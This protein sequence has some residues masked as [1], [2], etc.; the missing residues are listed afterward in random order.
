[1]SQAGDS[2]ES[3]DA[4]VAALC[5]LAGLAMYVG[6]P[7]GNI[8]GPLLV[9]LLGR[10]RNAFVDDQ[11]KEALNFQISFTIYAVVL[12]ILGVIAFVGFFRTDVVPIAVSGFALLIII[13]V[14]LAVLQFVL[15]IVAAV[16]AG[17]GTRY[18][19]PLTMRLIR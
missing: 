11:G 8:L 6:V 10:S 19:Y 14:I 5:H 18:R 12:F 13:G 2:T 15:V 9:W 3:K 7:L 16:Q 1:M 17:N 4:G